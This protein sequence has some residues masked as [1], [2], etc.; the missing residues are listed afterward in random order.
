MNQLTLF[1]L[2]LENVTL[3]EATELLMAAARAERP[4]GLVVTPNVDHVVMLERD[5]EMRRIFHDATYRFADGMPL[6]WLSRLLARPGLVARV[7]GADLL[8]SV[9]EAA[10]RDGTKLYFLGGLPGVADRAAIRLRE[11]FPDLNVAGRYCPPFGFERDEAE[12]RR[13]VQKVNASGA[14]ILFMG[15]GTPKQ[16]KWLDAWMPALNP[17]VMLGVGAAF[18]FVAGTARRAPARMQRWGL[19]WLWRLARDPRRLAHRY[20]VQDSYF[21]VLAAREFWRV[22][23]EAEN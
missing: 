9:A 3:G 17:R 16:E 4:G 10:A 12:C 7:T 18:D 21:A 2:T 5:A 14:S 19:E 8:V 6:V 13:I 23:R 1:D 20:L 22:R 15:V 11:R